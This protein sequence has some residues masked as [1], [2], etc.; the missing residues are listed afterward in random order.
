M[1]LFTR[2]IMAVA[3]AS[4]ALMTGHAATTPSHAAASCLNRMAGEGA[5]MGTGG[6]GTQ[7]AR[8]SAAT[9]WSRKVEARHGARFANFAKARGARYDCRTGFVLEVKCALSAQP[10]R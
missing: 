6:V 7:N 10:C 9:D 8:A 1:A 2:S 5:G 4:G 3:L